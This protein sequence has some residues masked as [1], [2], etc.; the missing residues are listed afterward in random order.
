VVGPQARRAPGAALTE[1][2]FHREG[3]A[4]VP[5]VHARGPWDPGQLHGGAPGA[6]AAQALEAEG[7]LVARL[8]VEF[9]APV[10]LVPLTLSART[11]KPGRNVQ[12]AEAELAAGGRTVLRVR[13][14]RLRRARVDL[15]ALEPAAATP[16]GPESG[17]KTPFPLDEHAEGFHLTGMEIRFLEGTSYGPGPATA[18]FRLARP[19]VDDDE[20]SP[21]A[22]AVAAADFG[23]GISRVLDFERYLFIN[24]DLT[25]HL[26]REPIGEWVLLD[27]Q[28]RIGGEGA[29]LARSR[30][31]D[32]SGEIGL[33]AQSLLVAPR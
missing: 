6:L 26:L 10:P 30:L 21:L 7:F 15:P 31:S 18:W 22:R 24:A 3:E 8:T 28:T 32:G 14:A 12:L 23:N 9:L 29:G 33:A 4:F 2:I 20:P 1:P 11:T 17:R 16:P 27:A 13:A 25:V 19:L 5:T